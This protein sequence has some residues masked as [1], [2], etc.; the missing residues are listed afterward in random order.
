MC[1]TTQTK[2]KSST[3]MYSITSEKKIHKQNK[4]K[5]Y[6]YVSND[7]NKKTA[8]LYAQKRLKKKIHK[9]NKKRQ[10]FTIKSV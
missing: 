2:Q 3:P 7:A 9:Q 8:F 5:Q 1:P 4:K 10:H 6:F